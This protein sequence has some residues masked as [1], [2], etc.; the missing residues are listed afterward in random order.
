MESSADEAYR[1]L[2][3]R[4]F[5]HP[6]SVRIESFQG[7]ARLVAVELDGKGGYSPGKP[8]RRAKRE[9]SVQEWNT[10]VAAISVADFWSSVTEDPGDGG[11]DGADWIL[12]GLRHGTYHVVVRWT[13]GPGR[14]RTACESLLEA[15]RFTFPDGEVY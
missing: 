11:L 13:P 9:L 4:T 8:F 14:F 6:V 15:A 10:I 7:K 2:W 1:F 12:E 3:L 5:H